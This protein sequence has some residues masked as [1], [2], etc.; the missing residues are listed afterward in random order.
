MTITLSLNASNDIFLDASGNIAVSRDIDA[1]AGACGTISRAQL[2]EMVFEKTR[3]IPNFQA[4][5][6]GVPNYKIWE[7]YLKNALQDVYGV[8]KVDSIEMRLL[9]NV[10]SYTARITTQFGTTTISG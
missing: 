5:W 7:T 8:D 4:L 2:G 1:V 9:N 10:L 6:V 3:G